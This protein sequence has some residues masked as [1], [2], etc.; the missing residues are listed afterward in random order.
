MIAVYLF[1]LIFSIVANLKL[2]EKLGERR[3]R[4]VELEQELA[5]SKKRADAL[6]DMVDTRDRQLRLHRTIN[7]IPG[8]AEL[9]CELVSL[10]KTVAL[11][12]ILQEGFKTWMNN[13][14][15]R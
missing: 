5:D 2:M 14:G 6:E 13:R 11:S 15:K 10:R 1:V 7:T 4:I 12:H 8:A 3:K 9:I